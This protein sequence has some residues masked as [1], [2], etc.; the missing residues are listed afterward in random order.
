MYFYVT[1]IMLY[2]RLLVNL[3]RLWNRSHE[4]ARFYFLRGVSL[5]SHLR[6]AG[7]TQAPRRRHVSVTQ[8]P[9]R[10][11]TGCSQI[12]LIAGY[13]EERVMCIYSTGGPA[14]QSK[15]RRVTLR[16]WCG[17]LPRPQ[18]S[19]YPYKI[20]ITLYI[21]RLVNWTEIDRVAKK[22]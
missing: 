20:S 6:H 5:A 22:A 17:S 15:I 9:R 21:L 4:C 12:G 2:T 16:F 11:H 19:G 10:L 14:I 18:E 1:Y 8:V 7:F 13:L 3:A